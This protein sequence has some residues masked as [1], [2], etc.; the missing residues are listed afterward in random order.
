MRKLVDGHLGYFRPLTTT[1]NAINKFSRVIWFTCAPISKRYEPRSRLLGCT[2]W[3]SLTFP[4]TAKRLPEVVVPTHCP[5]SSVHECFSSRHK[6]HVLSQI[7]S[8]VSFCLFLLLS[9]RTTPGHLATSSFVGSPSPWRSAREPWE[10]VWE[11]KGIT[12]HV[13]NL[14]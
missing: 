13:I 10:A 4:D 14:Y 6:P 9:T 11:R 1:N 5:V 7:P 12:S 3:T 2:V 8:T